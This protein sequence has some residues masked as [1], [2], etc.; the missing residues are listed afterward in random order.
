[1]AN[2]LNAQKGTYV[3]S[4]WKDNSDDYTPITPE[5]MNHMEQGIQKNSEDLKHL[6]DTWDS[7]NQLIAVE[8]IKAPSTTVPANSGA[9]TSKFL[10]AKLGYK[11]IGIVGF[12]T[13]D[14]KCYITRC[15]II[16]DSDMIDLLI[17]N[18]TVEQKTLTDISI[19]ILYIRE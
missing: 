14:Y 7:A 9:Y 18:P 11:P 16:S 4:E 1:M 15:H 5:R 13:Y 8:R 19:D 2:D 12:D 17:S 10:I 6:G 3:A